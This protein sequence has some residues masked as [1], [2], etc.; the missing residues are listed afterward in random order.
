[1]AEGECGG[2]EAYRNCCAAGI[3]AP[4][5]VALDAV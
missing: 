1:M 3:A 5:T 2:R 4:Y